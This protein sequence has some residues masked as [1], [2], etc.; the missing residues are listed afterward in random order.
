V[1]NLLL[2]PPILA[3]LFRLKPLVVV[4]LE[5]PQVMPVALVAART[6]KPLGLLLPLLWSRG[7]QLFIIE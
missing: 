4:V 6:Q 2:Y 7:Q 3:H 5:I 1:N